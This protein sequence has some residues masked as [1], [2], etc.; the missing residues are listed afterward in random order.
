MASRYSCH[1]D[2]AWSIDELAREAGTSVRNVRLYQ[3]RGLLPPPRRVGRRAVY[4]PVHADRLALVLDLLGRGYPIAGIKELLEAWAAQRSLG[5]VLGVDASLKESFATEAPRRF[6][7]EELAALFPQSTDATF[8]RALELG[9]I[10]G[11]GEEFVAP[12]PTLF[13]AGAQLAADG[14]PLDATLDVAEAIL[15]ASATLADTFVGM[16]LTHLWQP[17]VD[18]G[19]PEDQLAHVTA[20]LHRMRPLVTETTNAAL[21]VALQ[22]RVD[23]I[24]AEAPVPAGE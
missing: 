5:D 24:L 13:R 19:S 10:H 11:D 22:E 8:A 14:I 9:L 2:P 16:F 7:V 3:E 21:G 18:A 23:R 17:L 6:T 20:A 4:G 12:I 1:M 15:R